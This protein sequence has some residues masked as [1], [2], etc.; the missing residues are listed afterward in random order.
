MLTGGKHEQERI[1]E[2]FYTTKNQG[3][4]TGLGLSTVYGIITQNN[5]YIWVNSELNHGST[6][7]IYL[8]Q[9]AEKS[10]LQSTRLESPTAL[11]G[12]EKI[13]LVEDEFNVRFLTMKILLGAGYDVLQ[14]NN[15]VNALDILQKESK[16]KLI[17]TDVIMPEMGGKELSDKATKLY[18]NIKT[19]F[20]SGYT[21]DTISQS[22]LL[23]EGIIFLQ[24]PY[25]PSELLQLV[26]DTLDDKV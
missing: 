16:V 4:G 23:K 10:V 15:G 6:F 3:K 8:S 13:L 1:F 20:V 5:G 17:I 7:T 26:R 18:P 25:S 24:K 2:P 14:A 22:G 21:D 19:V 12:N 11:A 9:E